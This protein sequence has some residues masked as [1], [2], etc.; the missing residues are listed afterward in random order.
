MAPAHRQAPVEQCTTA[1]S[2]GGWEKSGI[3]RLIN[4]GFE[5]A[6]SINATE[7][8]AA[9][10]SMPLNDHDYNQFWLIAALDDA[11][12]QVMI[13]SVTSGGILSAEQSM[14]FPIQP[15]TPVLLT[16]FRSLGKSATRTIRAPP[17]EKRARWIM[18]R[19]TFAGIA[20]E[21]VM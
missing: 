20:G 21:P 17:Y 12:E 13:F 1:V 19:S 11:D 3:Y 5:S 9:V 14:G 4:Y 8:G 18:D 16:M 15:C 7:M 6:A 2:Y 10:V